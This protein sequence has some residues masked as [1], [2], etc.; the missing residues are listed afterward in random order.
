MQPVREI[1][2]SHQGIF[3]LKQTTTGNQAKQTAQ[4]W[5]PVSTDRSTM[6]L[7]YTNC[8]GSLQRGEQRE[9]KSQENTALPETVSPRKIRSHTHKVSSIRLLNMSQARTTT[10]VLQ[11][12]GERPRGQKE[13]QTTQ[14]CCEWKE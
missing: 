2:S 7:P 5:S 10:G 14:K 11:W 1:L 3:S 9:C 4:L 12:T 13:Q 6:Q 8:S